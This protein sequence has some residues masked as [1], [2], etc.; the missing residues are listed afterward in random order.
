MFIYDFVQL[1]TPFEEVRDRL[2][3][4]LDPAPDMEH[5]TL[6]LDRAVEQEGMIAVPFIWRKP[7]PSPLF[8]ALDGHLE[9]SRLGASRTHVSLL[10]NYRP[11]NGSFGHPAERMGL[12][13]LAEAQ[14]R[15]FLRRVADRL[16]GTGAAL[17]S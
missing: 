4:D 9:V 10:G 16:T 6:V 1:E 15:V 14:L 7:G 2:R 12:H 5:L 8:T 17:A 3:A 13:H 11:S